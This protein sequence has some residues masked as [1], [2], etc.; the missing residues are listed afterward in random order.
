MTSS[1]VPF[2]PR[3]GHPA[4]HDVF[5]S[6]MSREWLKNRSRVGLLLDHPL[7]GLEQLLDDL[8]ADIQPARGWIRPTSPTTSPLKIAD[9]C[10][11]RSASHN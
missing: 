9:T 5:T 10:F 8:V 3:G 1:V 11:G 4:F 6:A 2:F 7:P